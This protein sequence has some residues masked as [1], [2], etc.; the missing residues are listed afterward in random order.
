MSHWGRDRQIAHV[1]KKWDKQIY[2]CMKMPG[3]TDQQ[4]KK[5]IFKK[6]HWYSYLCTKY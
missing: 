3:N 6:W 1:L 2:A 5:E 4:G